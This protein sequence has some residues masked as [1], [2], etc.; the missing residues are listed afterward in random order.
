[1]HAAR[2]TRRFT[3]TLAAAFAASA[4]VLT[5]IGVY[6]VLAYAVARRRHELGIRR[7]LGASAGR[8]VREVLREGLTL[9]F[10]GCAGGL[11][12]ALLAGRLLQSQLYGVHYG[13][14]LVFAAGAALIFAGGA[15][16]CAVPAYRAAKVS[17]MDAMSG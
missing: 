10:V 8:M 7:A 12:A 14:P 15:I 13:D 3:V 9:A 2:G 4:L 11:V 6:G 17:P 5:C 16:A 1:V